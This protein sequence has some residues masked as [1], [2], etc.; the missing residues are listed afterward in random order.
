MEIPHFME[1][2]CKWG[3]NPLQINVWIL[4]VKEVVLVEAKNTQVVRFVKVSL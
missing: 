2:F 1:D 3:E 4:H